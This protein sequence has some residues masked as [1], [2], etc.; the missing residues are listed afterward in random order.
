MTVHTLLC[1]LALAAAA[2]AA[3]ATPQCIGAQGRPVAW[4]AALTLPHGL[5]Y[6][7]ADSDGAA[8]DGIHSDLD[9]GPLLAGT[10]APVYD[11]TPSPSSLAYA[12]WSD[13]PPSSPA[14]SAG[15]HAKAVMVLHAETGGGF[16]LAHSVPHWPPV[17]VFSAPLP[18]QRVHSQHFFCLTL[19]NQTATI[20]TTLLAAAV[21][22][23]VYAAVVPPSAVAAFPG[24]APLAGLAPWPPPPPGGV[25]CVRPDAW[26]TACA[27][28]GDPPADA[29][30]V[31]ASAVGAT[32]A[33]STWPEA[34]NLAASCGAS[35]SVLDVLQASWGGVRV[36]RGASHA[37]WGAALGGD[38]G[39]LCFGDT[40]R[41]IPQTRRAGMV[42][43]LHG[44]EQ[45]AAAAS[46]SVTAVD[47]CEVGPSA[48]V[49]W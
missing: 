39:V 7:Y 32:L 35:S 30:T 20:L 41:A 29:W 10:L 15:A 38:R 48:A 17:D 44:V 4:W 43:C 16:W 28:A 37:K 23:R 9:T 6:L 1:L 33:V 45:A 13:A 36:P 14:S 5:D 24:L 47:A 19:S 42:V 34:G 27:T 26:L 3:R 2:T 40:N 22:P 21:A 12:L 46:R 49:L 11:K 18:P 31:A 25:A 8:F